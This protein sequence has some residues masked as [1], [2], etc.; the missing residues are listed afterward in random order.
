[1]AKIKYPQLHDVE[2]LKANAHRDKTEIAKELGC[3]TGLVYVAFRKIG[4]GQH[5]VKMPTAAWL[6]HVAMRYS[7]GEIAEMLG[8]NRGAVCQWRKKL[9]IIGH[10]PANKDRIN[11][12]LDLGYSVGEVARM[13]RYSE[14]TVRKCVEFEHSEIDDWMAEHADLSDGEIAE[15]LQCHV[16]TVRAARRAYNTD[17]CFIKVARLMLKGKWH[18]EWCGRRE[19]VRH[20]LREMGFLTW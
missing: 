2:W 11:T 15:V 14:Y 13:L 17:P 16:Q 7:D 1:M 12:L 10:F 20:D 4:M 9:G 18:G 8:G 19:K 3:C 5:R 6:E